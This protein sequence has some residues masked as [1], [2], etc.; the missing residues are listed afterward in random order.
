MSGVITGGWE[1]VTAAYTI[2]F[3]VL[4]V[5]GVS[6]IARL[7]QERSRSAQHPE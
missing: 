7:R 4:L 5:Y 2:T 6:L 3:A 1:Y